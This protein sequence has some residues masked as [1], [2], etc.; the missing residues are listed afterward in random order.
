V[1]FLPAVTYL[2]FFVYV[3]LVTW[4]VFTILRAIQPTF[5]VP[6]TWRGPGRTGLPT[7]MIFYKGILDVSASKWGEAFE[8][9]SGE[10]GLDLKRYYAKCYVAEAYLVA[11]KVAQKLN[12]LRPGISALRGAMRVLIAFFLL[13]AATIVSVEANHSTTP[14][15]TVGKAIK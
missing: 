3:I 1:S 2:S 12:A 5:N 4:S 8:A 11:A 14:S 10:N 9:L 13:F 7:S 15:S 6:A